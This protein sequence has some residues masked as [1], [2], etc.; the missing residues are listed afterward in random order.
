M[1]LMSLNYILKKRYY[2]ELYYI[3]NIHTWI[4]LNIYIYSVNILF[5]HLRHFQPKW[6]LG[7][8]MHHKTISVPKNPFSCVFLRR[9]SVFVRSFNSWFSLER[10]TLQGVSILTLARS[11]FFLRHAQGCPTLWRLWAT[12]E[13]EELSWATRSHMRDIIT[14]K[15][16]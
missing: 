15:I 11:W 3:C 7:D 9:K 1:Y 4:L 16:S 2:G 12:L 14:K 13:E 6:A 8:N 5:F 10:N